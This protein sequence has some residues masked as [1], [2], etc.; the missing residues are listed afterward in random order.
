MERRIE[1]FVS[2]STNPL[3]SKEYYEAAIEFGKLLDKDKYNI[4]FDG[5]LGLPVVVA[6][7]FPSNHENLSIAYAT[8]DNLPY[9]WPGARRNGTFRYQ[10]EIT[11]ALLDWSNALIFFKGGTGL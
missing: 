6:S 4:V 7:Q 8:N 3:V 1:I 5:C 10:S 9:E 2:G 11:K